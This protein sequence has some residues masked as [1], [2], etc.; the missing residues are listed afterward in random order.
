MQDKRKTLEQRA[1]MTDIERLRHSVSHVLATAILKLW[2]E[3]QFAAGR[4]LRWLS[5][6]RDV[7]AQEFANDGSV[8]TLKEQRPCAAGSTLVCHVDAANQRHGQIRIPQELRSTG[9]PGAGRL[10]ASSFMYGAEITVYCE[11]VPGIPTSDSAACCLR[12]SASPSRRKP[13]LCSALACWT[14]R[15]T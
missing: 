3:A 7:L 11:Q 8:K 13:F 2:P 5:R 12:A 6:Q 15:S 10:T 1:T 14:T 9:L 4:G